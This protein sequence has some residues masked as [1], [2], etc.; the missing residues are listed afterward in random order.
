MLSITSANESSNNM[1]PGSYDNLTFSFSPT[2][3][4]V[5]GSVISLPLTIASSDGYNRQE[6]INATF[7]EVSVSDPLG[8]DEHGY[9]IYDSGDTDYDLAPTYDWIEIAEGLGD[10]LDLDDD[11]CLLY[12]SPSPRDYAA[13]RMP[14][15]A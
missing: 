4:F 12:T 6:F 10:N 13:S 5:P 1:S 11:G 3:L 8:P 7:G 15:S 2:P 14:S 9:F